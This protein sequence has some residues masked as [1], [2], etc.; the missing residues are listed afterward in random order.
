[1]LWVRPAHFGKVVFSKL[2]AVRKFAVLDSGSCNRTTSIFEHLDIIRDKS[3]L[4]SSQYA[5]GRRSTTVFRFLY[6][7]LLRTRPVAADQLDIRK[8]S[9]IHLLLTHTP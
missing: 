9:S 6:I 2:W 3:T 8:R 1:M 7:S 5:V 4:S